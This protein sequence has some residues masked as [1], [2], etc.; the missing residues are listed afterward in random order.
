LRWLVFAWHCKNSSFFND[1]QIAALT[2]QIAAAEGQVKA[3]AKNANVTLDEPP[4]WKPHCK[5]ETKADLEKAYAALKHPT[6]AEVKQHALPAGFAERM[7]ATTRKQMVENE[8]FVLGLLMMHQTRGDWEPEQYQDALCALNSGNPMLVR[9]YKEHDTK[10]PLA[11]QLAKLMDDERKAMAPTRAP[12]L[13]LDGGV[14]G[15]LAAAKR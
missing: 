7:E 1:C 2:A 10:L 13:D 6:N 8:E 12:P 3:A 5:P 11:I 15:L 9:L 4:A 14:K